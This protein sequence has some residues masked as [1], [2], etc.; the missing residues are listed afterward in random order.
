[1][2]F[3]SCSA[4]PIGADSTFDQVRELAE[5][6]KRPPRQWTPEVLWEAYERWTDPKVRRSGERTLADLAHS[7]ALRSTSE[8]ELVP[9]ADQVT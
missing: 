5:A 7:S 8:E 6:I 2:R 3:R 9:Y 1:M 4:A